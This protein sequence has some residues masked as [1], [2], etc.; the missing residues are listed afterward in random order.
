[1]HGKGSVVGLNNSVRN[2]RGWQNR[3]GAHLATRVLFTDPGDKKG[4]HTGASA[5][6]EGLGDLEA[7]KAITAFSLLTDNI[8]DGVN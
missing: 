3:E 8:K 4:A 2:L 6:T 1:M 7:H 5:T